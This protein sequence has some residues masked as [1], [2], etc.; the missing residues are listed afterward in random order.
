MWYNS[1]VAHPH[2][3][4]AKQITH[5]SETAEYKICTLWIEFYFPYWTEAL[6]QIEICVYKENKITRQ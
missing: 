3:K 2:G 1:G 5:K 6:V 4:G